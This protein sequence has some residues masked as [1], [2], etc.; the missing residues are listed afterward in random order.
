MINPDTR[1]I[2]MKEYLSEVIMKGGRLYQNTI[3]TFNNVRDA[4]KALHIAPCK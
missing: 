3:A 1:D 2:V 4:C